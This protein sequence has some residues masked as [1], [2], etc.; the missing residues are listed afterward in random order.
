MRLTDHFSLHEFTRSRTAAKMGISN[1][2]TPEHAAKLILLCEQ[3]LE[4][5]RDEVGVPVHITSGY[6]S[7]ELNAVI[8]GSRTSQHCRGEAADIIVPGFTPLAVCKLIVAM[9]LPFDQLIHEFGNDGWTH[10][11]YHDPAR[12]E[13]LT[14]TH[15]PDFG[16]QYVKGLWSA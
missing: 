12:G 5:L 16:V 15:H 7:A 13:T 8:H 4:P 2:P 9:K 11:S 1:E 6:R 3:I 10:V 14:A